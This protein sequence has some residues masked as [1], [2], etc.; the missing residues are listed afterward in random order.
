MASKPRGR[1]IA[2]E[3]TRGP[4]LAETARKLVRQI[5][6]GKIEGG[7]SGWDASGIFYEL[8]KG[9]YDGPNPSPRTLLLLYASDLAFRLRWEIRP[10]VEEGMVVVAAPYVESA[11]AFGK[12]AGISRRW[13]VDLFSFAPKS[14]A[15][16]RLKEKRETAEWRG[17]RS[18]GFLE[19]CCKTLI[20]GSPAWNAAE[21][22]GKFIDYLEALEKRGGCATL[23]EKLLAGIS[24]DKVTPGEL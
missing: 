1:L 11:I 12:A 3:G 23:T 5:C 15:C 21:I 16:Y 22:Q 2:L 19:F 4:E 10:A 9:N 17:K 13:L 6:R 20:K 24:A 8:R 18:E 7:A 14:D